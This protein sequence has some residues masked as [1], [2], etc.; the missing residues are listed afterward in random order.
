[1][2]LSSSGTSNNMIR[3]YL[4]K[5]DVN[6]HCII[7][8]LFV[9]LKI[10]KGIWRHHFSLTFQINFIHQ[11]TKTYPTSP[12]LFLDWTSCHVSHFMM[13][14][15][16]T[17]KQSLFSFSFS[18][19]NWINNH[20]SQEGKLNSSTI[21]SCTKCEDPWLISIEWYVLCMLGY[22]CQNQILF[23][24]WWHLWFYRILFE[25]L[26]STIHTRQ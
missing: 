10:C 8:Y 5:L 25:F 6:L 24:I 2:S 9:T 13:L 7:I 11:S 12:H 3:V 19:L 20:G 4:I 21:Y 18:L 15:L 1:M 23:P 22:I 17:H 14:I 26:L 16:W